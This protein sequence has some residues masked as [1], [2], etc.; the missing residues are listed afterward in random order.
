MKRYTE[1]S[2][3][4]VQRRTPLHVSATL[5]RP[6]P[7]SVLV[8]GGADL[9]AGGNISGRTPLHEA[10]ACL[11]PEAVKRLLDLG[12]SELAADADGRTPGALVGEFLTEEDRMTDP[13]VPGREES[14]RR[15]LDGAP[16]ERRWRRRRPLLLLRWR[17][18]V[19]PV[20]GNEQHAVRSGCG[21][22]GSERSLTD[23]LVDLPEGVVRNIVTYF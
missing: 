15:L 4:I 20:H 5:G 9:E 2:C 7:I 3:H 21:G 14:I 10:C 23:A 13:G 1:I 16:K 6:G 17:H 22:A 12:A 18:R 11:R 19:A 8:E